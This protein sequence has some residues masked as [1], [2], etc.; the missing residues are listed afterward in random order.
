[1]SPSFFLCRRGHG[2]S[3]RRWVSLDIVI[4]A[5]Y[6]VVVLGI[7]TLPQAVPVSTC[8]DFFMAG[9]KMTAW[10]AGLSFHLGQ[11]QLARDDGLVG[12]GLPV[13]EYRPRCR[14]LPD[15][16]DSGDPL[17]GDRHDAVL[18]YLQNPLG[19]RDT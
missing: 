4:I 15:R 5:I 3:H 12:H 2:A 18:L 16:G 8:E 6:F 14:R 19:A 13:R 7:G 11:P 1:M 17:P 10:V 9:R